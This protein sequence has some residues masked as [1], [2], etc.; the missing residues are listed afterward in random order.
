M[1]R[2][3]LSRL[4]LLLVLFIAAFAFAQTDTGSIQGTV[5]DNS[6]AAISGAAI[7]ATNT[8]SGQIYNA[9]SDNSGI[10]TIPAV[11]RGPYKVDISAPN[12]ST[13]SQNFLLNISERKTFNAV[14]APGATTQ[15]V[16][17][18]ASGELVDTTTSSTGEVIQGRQVVELPLNGRNFTQLA[19]LTPGVTRGAY[20]DIASGVGNSAETFRNGESGGAALSVNGLRPQANNFLLDGL[21]N[22]E[23]LVN[24]INFFPPVEATQ[25]FKVN[26]SVAPAEFGRAG[27]GII[28]TSIKSGTNQIHGSAF[29]FLR[30]S[31]FDAS[32]NYFNPLTNGVKTP[33][34]PFKRNQFGGTLGGPIWKNKLF[35][36]GDYQGLRQDQPLNPEQA[37]VPTALMRTGN[38][39]ELL[40]TGLT[41]FPGETTDA[42]GNITATVPGC[43]VVHLPNGGILNPATCMQYPGNIIPMTGPGSAEAA[44]LAYLNAYPAPNNANAILQNYTAV[45]KDVRNFNDFDVRLDFNATSRDTVFARYSYGQDIYQLTPRLPTLPSGFGSGY[46]VDHPRGVA[47]GE[48]H[49]FG[50]SLV[51]DFRYGY[52]RPYYAY[53]NP[54]NNVPVSANLG[55]VNA[56]RNSLLGGGALIGGNNNEI[57][58]TGDGGPYVVPQKSNQFE[59]TVSYVHGNH[60]F[61]FGANIIKREVDF[62]Q[63][64]SAKGYFIIGGNNF[65]GTGRFTGYEVSELLS[66]FSDY[67]LGSSQGLYKTNNYETGYFGQDDWKV[68]PR[69]TLNLGLRYDLYTNP[70]ADNNQ[71]SNFDLNTGTLIVAGTG[72]PNNSLVRTDKNNLAPRI[73][74]AYDLTG[75][76]KTVLRGGYGVFY[77]LDRGGVGN[78]LSNNPDFN[79]TANYSAANGYRITLQGQNAICLTPTP[80]CNDASTATLAL[81]AP[82]VTVNPAAPTG[83]VI[84][85]LPNN[86]TSAI[87]QYNLQ[88]TQEL[89]SNTA[90][91]VAYVGT[92]AD[93]LLTYFNYNNASDTVGGVATFPTLGNVTVGAATGTSHY[94]G[95][96]TSLNRRMNNGLQFTAAYTWSHTTDDSNGAFSTTGGGGRIIVDPTLG[97]LLRY[98][99]GNSDQDQRHAF[100]FASLYELPFGRNHMYGANWNGFTDALLGG[101]QLNLITSI[102][103]GT[104][105][106]LV[107]GSARPDYNGSL[108]SLGN[109]GHAANGNIIY[110]SA[111]AGTFT[112]AAGLIP[113]LGRNAFHGPGYDPVD[114]SVFKN[115]V[116][117]ERVKMELRAEGYNL[118]NTPQFVN[119]NTNVNDSA[120]FGTINATRQSSERELQFAVRFT[121]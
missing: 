54:F 1:H 18:S 12:F 116:I 8:A 98:N 90:L 43:G 25:E 37:S 106:D 114:A 102:G 107:A 13:Q 23:S 49:T 42:A 55:I 113:T 53:I 15:T 33:V 6:G 32:P 34:Q 79:G 73:G 71:Q 31:A 74:F 38:F 28:Q 58:Y 69:L 96:Q 47:A 103:S 109:Q 22:N 9:T 110:I 19:L 105:F 59:D 51:N 91:N 108:V 50:S 93:H 10:Y 5:T 36:F 44:G 45:R 4:A 99:Y 86:Q 26:T 67:T 14:L 20:G 40:G 46:N 64:N 82:T 85:D 81:P 121:F 7:T 100:T 62:F 94:N 83:N 48:T 101:W 30:N 21:D 66:G 72:G 70:T 35:L 27:G 89:G 75:E 92:K 120:N 57:E 61:R 60:S 117:T 88:M 68:T 119:P 77:F 56:N 29:E 2:I 97:G 112:P 111:P 17:V 39:S 95:L 87:Q 104:P 52:S 41:S 78:Q 76:G 63:G 24:T 16:E 118:L 115:F 3:A 80:A 65:P 11:I 84:A